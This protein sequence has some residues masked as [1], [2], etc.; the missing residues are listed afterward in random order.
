MLKDYEKA[1]GKYKS[2]INNS[3]GLNQISALNN[4]GWTQYVMNPEA[5]I[6]LAL[7]YIKKAIATSEPAMEK[8]KEDQ[9]NIEKDLSNFKGTNK[10][11]TIAIANITEI[12]LLRNKDEEIRGYWMTL[13]LKYAEKFAP[14]CLSRQLLLLSKQYHA[15]NQVM[16]Y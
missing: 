13:G 15:K 16:F 4:L 3:S 2:V 10:Q 1:I 9:T 5:D 12:L 11:L 14:E 7:N 6:E 8:I